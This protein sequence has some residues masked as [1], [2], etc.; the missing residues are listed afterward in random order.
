MK[1]RL[2]QMLVE[3]GL[4]EN[5]SLAAAYIMEGKVQVKGIRVDKPGHQVLQTDELSLDLPSVSYVSRGG[6]KLAGALRALG[7]DVKLKVALDV[8]SSTGGFTDCLL[9]H[10]A[11][12]VFAIDVGYGL[13][14]YKLRQDKRVVLMEGINFRHFEPKDVMTTIDIATIDVSFISLE[15]ILPNVFL[16]LKSPGHALALIKP[17]FEL[18]QRDVERG[19]IVRSAEKQA[20]AVSKIEEAAKKIGFHVITV[21]P[22]DIKGTKGNQEFFL[23]LQ[24]P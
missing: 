21:V 16:C 9:Q 19:G 13:L 7:I 4:A 20:K 6:L 23:Y 18:E 11:E 2:D 17:Q 3:K 5:L 22:S 12:K 10:G 8:G 24:K 1:K 14:D 15:L